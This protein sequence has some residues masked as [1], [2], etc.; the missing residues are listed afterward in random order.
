MYGFRDQEFNQIMDSLGEEVPA[1]ST[2][3]KSHSTRIS[4]VC[5]NLYT[6]LQQWVM[7]TQTGTYSNHDQGGL[8]HDKGD[9]TTTFH[10]VKV[11]RITDSVVCASWSKGSH[12]HG[13]VFSQ[14]P[15]HP[16]HE[17]PPPEK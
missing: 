10:M 1:Y 2:E 8:N 11:A 3:V 4:G 12:I 13:S 6:A 17:P 15:E 9:L 5:F 7:G 14:K 16:P